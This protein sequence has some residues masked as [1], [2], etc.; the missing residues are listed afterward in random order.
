MFCHR[1]RVNV[2]YTEVVLDGFAMGPK[3]VLNGIV[4]RIVKASAFVRFREAQPSGDQAHPRK[5][6]IAL[7]LLP[8]LQLS[9]Y[10]VGHD[11]VSLFF[12]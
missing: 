10:G 4:Y 1:H 12:F 9:D 5:R 6:G 3:Y 2:T 11:C 7:L 8:S